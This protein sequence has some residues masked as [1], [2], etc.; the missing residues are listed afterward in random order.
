MPD[1]N[2]SEK[3]ERKLGESECRELRRLPFGTRRK[4]ARV[5]AVHDLDGIRIEVID[6]ADGAVVLNERCVP[7][8]PCPVCLKT[9]LTV[10]Y[11]LQVD[12]DDPA[13]H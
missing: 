6:E 12:I 1:Q 5:E 3:F 10:T 13:T 7:P 4:L 11:N 2:P 9:M 8:T